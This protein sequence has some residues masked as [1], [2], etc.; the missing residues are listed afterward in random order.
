M[1]TAIAKRLAEIRSGQELS[2]QA[3][4]DQLDAR[5]DYRVSYVTVLAYESEEGTKKIPA[6]YCLAVAR[7]YGLPIEYVMGMTDDPRPPAPPSAAEQALDMTERQ[8]QQVMATLA[9]VRRAQAL[10]QVPPVPPASE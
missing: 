9:A 8:L 1:P 4:A 6:E 3:F 7:A 2:A 5:A 10:G